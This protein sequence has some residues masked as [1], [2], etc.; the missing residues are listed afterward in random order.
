MLKYLLQIR[1]ECNHS[2]SHRHESNGIIE[3]LNK[4]VVRHLRC[5]INELKK[6]DKWSK[7]IPLVQRILNNTIHSVTKC[8]PSQLLY[9]NMVTLDRKLFKSYKS[10]SSKTIDSKSY[11]AELLDIQQKL[12]HASQ[13]YLARRVDKKLAKVKH[14]I[15]TKYNVGDYVLIKHP[16]NQPPNKLD[17]KWFGPMQVVKANRSQYYLLDLVSGIVIDRHSTFIKPYKQDSNNFS[18]LEVARRDKQEYIVDK[19][20][21]HRLVNP[22]VNDNLKNNY[23]FKIR[24]LGYDDRDDSWIK[25]KGIN[26]LQALDIYLKENKTL[27]K[28]FKEK[29]K[30]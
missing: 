15:P 30:E 20:V 3:R 22:D 21:A 16:D 2:I 7:F 5:F 19:I 8:S 12:L 24:W 17:T 9:G 10:T 29:I 26:K 28:K 14:V 13:V 25:W 1:T 27:A 11:L 6:N 4:E 18:P 23:E